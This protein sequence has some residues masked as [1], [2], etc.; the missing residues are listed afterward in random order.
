M[1]YTDSSRSSASTRRSAFGYR[2]LAIGGLMLICLIGTLIWIVVRLRAE[3]RRTRE[4]EAAAKASQ[5]G[6]AV[7]PAPAVEDKFHQGKFRELDQRQT[8]RCGLVQYD[9]RADRIRENID[10]FEEEAKIWYARVEELMRTKET[11]L[12]NNRDIVEYFVTQ[13]GNTP[14]DPSMARRR[15]EEINELI[16]VVKLARG[17]SDAAYEPSQAWLDKFTAVE[18]RVAKEKEAY[19]NHRLAVEEFA[20][21]IGKEEPIDPDTLR[22]E[23]RKLERKYA[24]EKLGY[25]GS[26]GGGQGRTNLRTTPAPPDVSPPAAQPRSPTE[27][28]YEST[29]RSASGV[30]EDFGKTT[31]LRD[32]LEER[33]AKGSS[34]EP[35]Y[36]P[37]LTSPPKP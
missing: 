30:P 19:I 20:A 11:R 15:R 32:I 37:R 13:W 3:A 27:D 23:V 16:Y 5:A 9:H 10:V 17:Q 33:P 6:G 34:G 1:V 26:S 22:A 12:K 4:A 36:R 14:P 25:P 28:L 31:L 2:Q 24:L 35:G 29:N 8:M 18:D 21:M 7:G